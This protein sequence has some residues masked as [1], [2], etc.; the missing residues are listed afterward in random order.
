M[1]VEFV[2]KLIIP[3]GVVAPDDEVSVTV[4]VHVVWLFTWTD[5]GLQETVVLVAWGGGDV[6]VRLTV[7]GVVVAPTGEPVTVKLYEPAA[8]EEAT[9]MVRP[10]DP[11]GVTGLMVKGPQVMPEGRLLLTHDK[12]TG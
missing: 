1:P 6:T 7:V 3:V 8:T 4:A 12:V 10:L 2:E 11:V 5:G 9:L